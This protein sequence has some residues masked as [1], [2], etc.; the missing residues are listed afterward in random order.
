MK[1]DILDALHFDKDMTVSKIF[2]TCVF[3]SQ[4]LSHLTLVA[5][6]NTFTLFKKR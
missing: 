5:E 6:G 1:D 4:V 3:L 2:V